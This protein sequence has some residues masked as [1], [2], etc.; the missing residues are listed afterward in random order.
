MAADPGPDED[1]GHP[2]LAR[3][4]IEHRAA[5]T[6]FDAAGAEIVSEAAFFLRPTG[7]TRL[8]LLQRGLSEGVLTPGSAPPD[9][10]LV[11][12]HAYGVRAQI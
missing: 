6:R 3:W 5:L 11:F 7:G 8:A 1:W 2:L 9:D 12:Q 10:S 4:G